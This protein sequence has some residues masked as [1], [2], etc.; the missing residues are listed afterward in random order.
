M[1]KSKQ[2]YTKHSLFCRVLWCE[3]PPCVVHAK[4]RG[5]C[6]L[7]AHVH[8]HAW[9]AENEQPH[10]HQCH[11]GRVPWGPQNPRGVPVLGQKQLG[12]FYLSLPSTQT[13]TA[14]PVPREMH[15]RF[16]LLCHFPLSL[17][18]LQKNHSLFEVT[19]CLKSENKSNRFTPSAIL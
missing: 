10:H 1:E 18:T 7:Q 3:I 17:S 12:P 11:A 16:L 5:V 14:P 13:L 8:G 4:S 2:Y 9:C 15:Y 6:M 19:F